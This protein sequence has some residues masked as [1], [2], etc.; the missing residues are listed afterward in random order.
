MIDDVRFAT[1]PKITNVVE[2]QGQQ[3]FKEFKRKDSENVQCLYH[4][5]NTRVDRQN[6]IIW[7]NALKDSPVEKHFPAIFD[8]VVDGVGEGFDVADEGHIC[9]QRGSQQLVGDS[10]RRSNCK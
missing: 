2:Q 8:P 9:S 4:E 3:L 10:Y 6:D 1:A 5:L 7:K